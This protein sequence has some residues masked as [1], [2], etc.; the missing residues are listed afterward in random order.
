[1]MLD[2][3]PKMCSMAH[4][5]SSVK[6][7][8]EILAEMTPQIW[9]SCVLPRCVLEAWLLPEIVHVSVDYHL[10]CAVWLQNSSTAKVQRIAHAQVFPWSTTDKIVRRLSF[11]IPS[12]RRYFFFFRGLTKMRRKRL[13]HAFFTAPFFTPSPPI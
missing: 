9:S 8:L 3:R 5:L 11:L 6:T 12:S 2:S 1:M 10:I 7:I 4:H 13:K